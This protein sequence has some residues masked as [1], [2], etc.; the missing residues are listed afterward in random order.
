VS[1]YYQKLR[2]SGLD[3]CFSVTYQL[4]EDFQRY[5]RAYRSE[6]IKAKTESEAVEAI[7]AKHGAALREVREVSLTG[8]WSSFESDLSRTFQGD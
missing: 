4:T 1:E 8:L 7:K 2:E 6:Y 3:L 5:Q